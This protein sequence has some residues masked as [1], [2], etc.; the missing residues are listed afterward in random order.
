MWTLYKKELAGFF[1][2]VVGY[3]AVIVFLVMVGLTLWVFRS[4][5]NILD[6][7]YS[8]MDGLFVMAPF[9]YLFLIPA[10]TMRMFG[11]GPWSSC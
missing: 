10:I 9:L 3:L 2:S 4:P 11:E 1:T 8:A 5:F 7:G 6:D